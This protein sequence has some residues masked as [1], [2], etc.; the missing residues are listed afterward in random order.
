MRSR[1]RCSRAAAMAPLPRQRV[2]RRL[3]SNAPAAHWSKAASKESGSRKGCRMQSNPAV[4]H[5]LGRKGEEL[6]ARDRHE[7]LARA[8]RHGGKS[9]ETAEGGEDGAPGAE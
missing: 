7:S 6:M 5:I 8:R 4:V 1:R 3:L 9:G 2:H